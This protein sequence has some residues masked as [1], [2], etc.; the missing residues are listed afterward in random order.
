MNDTC[1]IPPAVEITAGCEELVFHPADT[2]TFKNNRCYINNVY[3]GDIIF[4]RGN[5]IEVRCQNGSLAHGSI[6]EFILTNA[7][8]R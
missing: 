2:Y 3:F 5:V 1:L 7:N 4:A 8:R 6:H